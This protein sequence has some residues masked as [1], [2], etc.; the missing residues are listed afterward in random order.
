[1]KDEKEY[2]P[3]FTLIEMLVVIAI[4]TLLISLMTPA[5]TKSLQKAREAKSMSNL[6]SVG[7]AMLGFASENKGNLPYAAVDIQGSTFQQ[8]WWPQHLEPYLSPRRLTG[9]KTSAG[10]NQYT[11]SVLSDPLLQNGRHHGLGDYGANLEIIRP[12]R[13][14]DEEYRPFKL[15]QINR[16]S[17]VIAVSSAERIWNGDPGHGTWIYR[18]HWFLSNPFTPLD[19]PSDRG[20]GAMVSLFVDGSVRKVPFKVLLES[21]SEYFYNL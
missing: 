3:G 18:P 4:I 12:H 11:C 20:T 14:H 21:G 1:M 8:P 9:R 6:Q 17:G 15:S 2:S 10:T 13:P 7:I 19:R 16:P 5:V